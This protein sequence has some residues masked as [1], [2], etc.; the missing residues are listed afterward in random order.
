VH[1]HF[2]QKFAKYTLEKGEPHPE[3]WT[4]KFLSNI[5]CSCF[6]WLLN[7]ADAFC[8]HCIVYPAIGE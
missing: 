8:A 3:R 5:I 2:A 7:A 6:I 1:H 4:L